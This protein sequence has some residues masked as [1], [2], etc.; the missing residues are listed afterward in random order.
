[1]S[2][3]RKMVDVMMSRE[4]GAISG[5]FHAVI[6]TLQEKIIELLGHEGFKDYIF[7]MVQESVIRVEKLGLK[8]IKGE[9][10]EEALS[11][12]AQLLEK[13]LL[14]SSAEFRKKDESTYIFVLNDCFMAK[15]AHIVAETKGI[16]PMAMVAAAIV[17]KYSGK[18]A[19]IEWSKLTER[20]SVT[21]IK[22]V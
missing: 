14:V 13:S 8:S 22:L 5:L 4:F 17:Q 9:N 6:F 10:I 3:K 18:E 20:G 2:L 19:I 12:F 15:T 21:E 7:P 16:C 11:K 1:M